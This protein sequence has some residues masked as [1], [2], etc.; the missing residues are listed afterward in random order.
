AADSSS[1]NMVPGSV[2]FWDVAVD[3][4]Q[5]E[6]ACLDAAQ[7]GLYRD[8]ML[9]T[10]SNLVSVVGSSISKPDLIVFLEQEKEPWMV[11]KAEA[12]R[13]DS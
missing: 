1:E 2:T 3:F 5:E 12:S 13:E 4:S 11:V 9:E 10:Y 8:M 7:R 6:W